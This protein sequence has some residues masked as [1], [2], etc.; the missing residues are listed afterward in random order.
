MVLSL[1][2]LSLLAAAALIAAAV[3][4]VTVE[5]LANTGIFGNGY[6]DHNQLTVVPTLIAGVL[7]ALELLAVRV[8]GSLCRGTRGGDW[9]VDAASTFGRLGLGDVCFG[10]AL[11]LAALFAM[12]STEQLVAGQGLLGG[13]V[14][15]GAPVAIS[16]AIHAL[17]GA[18]CTLLLAYA[19]RALVVAAKPLRTLAYAA[20][21]VTLVTRAQAP[22]VRQIGG[23]APPLPALA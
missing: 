8:F 16:L 23:R 5:S 9:L 13:V 15:L 1:S 4:D 22:H 7:L 6:S 12:E 17:I 20:R 14:W 2:R 3:G 11:Q 19:M 10:V 18:G 21:G